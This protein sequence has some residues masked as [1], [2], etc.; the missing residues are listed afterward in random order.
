MALDIELVLIRPYG[1]TLSDKQ[2]KRAGLDYWQHV[3]LAEYAS[4]EEFLSDRSPRVDQ[5]FLFE[6]FGEES[7]YAPEYPVDALLVFGS[8]TKG[9]APA[10]IE[11]HRQRLFHLPMLSDKVRS[12]NLSN[13][14]TA[15]VYQALRGH[16]TG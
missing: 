8:E 9:L 15:V 2:L 1:F 3:R 4:W 6:E 11:A 5:M 16:F 13:T 10:I 14:V 12:L 7:F